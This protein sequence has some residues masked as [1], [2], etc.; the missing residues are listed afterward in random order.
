MKI[1][2]FFKNKAQ[3][4]HDVAVKANDKSIKPIIK[5]I[6]SDMKYKIDDAAKNGHFFFRLTIREKFDDG[7][8]LSPEIADLLAKEFRKDGYSVIVNTDFLIIHW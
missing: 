3:L 2:N 5:S 7:K 1:L 4:S 6:K 8:D